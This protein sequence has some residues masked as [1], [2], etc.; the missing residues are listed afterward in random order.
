MV[1]EGAAFCGECGAPT[2]SDPALEGSDTVVYPEIAKANLLRLRGEEKEAEKICLAILRRFPNNPA[3]HVLL[4]DIKVE[5]GKLDQAKQWYEMALEL[6]PENAALRAKLVRLNETLARQQTEYGVSGLEVRPPSKG[7]L[8]LLIAG[9]LMLCVVAALAFWLG[10]V[11]RKSRVDAIEPI[12]INGVAPPAPA[13]A[14]RTESP[15]PPQETTPRQKEPTKSDDLRGAVSGAIPA[16]RII[17]LELG[18]DGSSASISIKGGT[19]DAIDAALVGSAAIESGLSTVAIQVVD[20]SSTQPRFAATVTSESL[21]NA[22]GQQGTYE[23]A[24]SILVNPNPP[25]GSE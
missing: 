14:Q 25:L 23:W 24:A 3:S 19:Q 7:I 5:E 8:G 15:P 9:A 11:S 12:S 22:S 4:G 13:T 21:K 17:G 18:A 1:E 6:T 20:P 16:D 10:S 2:N